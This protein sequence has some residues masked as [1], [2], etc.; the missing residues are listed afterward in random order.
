MNTSYRPTAYPR[1]YMLKLISIGFEDYIE[2]LKLYLSRYKEPDTKGSTKGHESSPRRDGLQSDYDQN[3][4]VVLIF[5][6]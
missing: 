2:P 5:F 3:A 1:F 6:K 4:Q